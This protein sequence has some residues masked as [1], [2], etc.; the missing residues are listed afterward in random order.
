L[1]KGNR[2]TLG[3]GFG[4]HFADRYID[5]WFAPK[6]KPKSYIK[7][8]LYKGFIGGAINSRH[9]QFVIDDSLKELKLVK[10]ENEK[11]VL[12]IRNIRNKIIVETCIFYLTRI[13]G[14]QKL[15]YKY[16]RKQ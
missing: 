2:P 16:K 15:S 4:K 5:I 6:K 9:N 12:P 3:N 8:V 13:T 10:I 11:V 1:L 7:G 14:D